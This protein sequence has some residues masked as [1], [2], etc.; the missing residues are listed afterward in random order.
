MVEYYIDGSTKNNV[1]GVGIVKIDEFGF[2][3]KHHFTVEHINPTS[4]IAEGF[5][6]ERALR[7]IQETDLEKKEIIDIYTDCQ[8]IYHSFLYNQNSEFNRSSFFI[9]QESDH[10]FNH[11]RNLYIDLI[12]RYSYYPLF[13][14]DK[15]K[16]ARPFIKIF[17]KDDAKDKKYLQDAHTLSRNYLKEDTIKPVKMELKAIKKDDKWVIIKNNKGIVAENKRPLIALSEALKNIDTNHTQIK[18]CDSLETILKNT[19]INKL[20]NESMKSAVK[21][22]ESHNLLMNL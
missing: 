14:C 2:I 7:I 5:S 6:L 11:L 8:R 19:N 13:F 1:I 20:A 22:I 17:F 15:T 10:Y 18:L 16:Q 9:K 21:I 3:E 12:S 4:N